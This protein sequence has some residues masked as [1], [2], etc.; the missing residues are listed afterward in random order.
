MSDDFNRNI[1][2]L[3]F[4]ADDTLWE[5]NV[6]YVRATDSLF[7]LAAN[8]S[9]SR[10]EIEKEFYSLEHKMVS[11][12]GYGSSVF[13]RILRKFF[14]EFGGFPKTE[15]ITDRFEQIITEFESRWDKKP[16]LFPGVEECLS[17]L[18]GQYKHYIL[19]KGNYDEQLKK[20]HLSGLLKYFEGYFIEPEKN[21]ATLERILQQQ[22][23]NRERV[24]MIGNSPKSDINPALQLGLYAI[25][26][27]YAHT[28]KLDNENVLSGYTTLRI[29]EKF[30]D[31]SDLLLS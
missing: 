24:C 16:L 6:Y 4:D 14:I 1:D 31:L 19:T 25:F 17:V 8:S 23:W 27:P 13:I 5:N 21:L 7:E 2:I 29:A 10:I 22:K 18:N 20:I 30:S 12:L 15:F 9:V 11:Q 28:W 26:I 3:I